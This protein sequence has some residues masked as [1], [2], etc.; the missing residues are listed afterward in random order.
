METVEST[1]SA[2]GECPP[3]WREGFPR[4]R[5]WRGLLEYAV[6]ARIFLERRDSIAMDDDLKRVFERLREKTGDDRWY[7]TYVPLADRL[8]DEHLTQLRREGEQTNGEEH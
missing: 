4:R 5:T 7:E 8:Y 3:F 2:K 6:M 1:T